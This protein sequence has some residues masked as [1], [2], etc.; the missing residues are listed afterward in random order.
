MKNLKTAKIMAGIMAMTMVMGLSSCGESSESSTAENTSSS[1]SS[2]A[3]SQ[4][5]NISSSAEESVADDDS[6]SEYTDDVIDIDV[7]YKLSN[8]FYYDWKCYN[9][10]HPY[11]NLKDDTCF[12]KVGQLCNEYN[13]LTVDAS[14]PEEWLSTVQDELAKQLNNGYTYVMLDEVITIESEEKV[15]INDRTFVKFKGSFFNDEEEKDVTMVGYLTVIEGDE[16]L[17][18]YTED[19]TAGFIVAQYSDVADI[20]VL[21]GYARDAAESMTV[22]KSE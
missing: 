13:G 12:L 11:S 21:D 7:H 20:D 10:A 15:V 4:A 2:I 18:E 19:N 6:S 22:G 9:I 1:S 16:N 3:E 8:Y 14:K 5:E 17:S